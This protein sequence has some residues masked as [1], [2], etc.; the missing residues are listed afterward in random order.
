[1]TI[2]LSSA[3]QLITLNSIIDKTPQRRQI[4]AAQIT[5][6]A[7]NINYNQQQQSSRIT[8]INND[9]VVINDDNNNDSEITSE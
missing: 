2:Q 4:S 3:K 7:S 1:M 9:I 8:D 6:A 5:V